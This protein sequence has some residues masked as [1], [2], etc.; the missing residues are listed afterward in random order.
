MKKDTL[1]KRVGNQGWCRDWFGDTDLME[2][3]TNTNLKLHLYRKI[4]R[5]NLACVIAW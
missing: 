4:L 5:V 1:E 3:T 2:F